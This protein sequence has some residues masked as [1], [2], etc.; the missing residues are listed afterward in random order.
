MRYSIITCIV[1]AAFLAWQEPARAQTVGMLSFQGLIRDAGGTPIPTSQP[2]DLEFT[3]WTA[4]SGGSQVGGPWTQTGLVPNGGIVNT[5]FGPVAASA[6]DGC[7]SG[8]ACR[9]L[10]VRVSPAGM[11][12]WTT[13]SRTELVTPPGVAE[14]V[15]RPATGTSAIISGANGNVGI[16]TPA[17]SSKLHVQQ[18]TN[19][20]LSGFLVT[21]TSVIRSLHLWVDS[22]N[23]GRIDVGSAADSPIC[24][25]GAGTGNVGIGTTDPQ[26]KLSIQTGS[27]VFGLSHSNGTIKLG[28]F[29]GG[30]GN[31]GYFGTISNHPLH[32]FTNNN[33]TARMSITSGGNIG[34][35][36]ATPGSRLDVVGE[37]RATDG[38]FSARGGYFVAHN[39]NN[40]SAS[41]SLNWL[42]DVPRIRV[43][44]TGDGSS[45]GFDIQ[46]VSDTSRLRILHNGNIGIGT[47]NPNFLLEVNGSAGK[48]GGGSWSSS[49]DGR[50]KK[51]IS[52]LHNALATVL[53][54]RGVSFEYKDPEAIHELS[55]RRIGMIAQE[56]E[57]VVPDW[58]DDGPGG[59]K[60]VTYRGFEAL[61]TEAIRDLKAENDELKAR[62]AA[63]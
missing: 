30:T 46:V 43:A 51:N 12:S 3:L 35:G 39:P 1:V 56:V 53:R 58:V 61:T 7:T 38:G 31:G 14:Q 26:E 55:G 11:G 49:S 32:L 13:L 24:L 41:V 17:P 5:K 34:I 29:V 36:T 33:P 22:S 4:S 10:Q 8:A 20:N 40:T 27:N 16:G 19:T 28:S 60:R 59:Y 57:K 42:N 45:N 63:R 37:I 2:V 9:W 21:N 48:P 54:L 52:P 6:F 25:N 62:L 18:S 50:L 47:T 23:R 15:N 44:G